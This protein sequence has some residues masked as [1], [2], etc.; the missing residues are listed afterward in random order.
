MKYILHTTRLKV[1]EFVPDD[2]PFIVDL[3]NTPGWIENIGDRNIHTHEDAT[4]YIH[5]GP[6]RSYVLHGFGLWLVEKRDDNAPLGMCGILKREYLNEPD[7]GFAFLP[8][9][10]GQGF[11]FEVASETINYA[12]DKLDIPVMSAITLAKNKSS[13][14]LLEKLGLSFKK[15]VHVA[16][17]KE[18]LLLFSN[19]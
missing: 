1:R 12:K 9:Y 7:I 15:I 5:N 17:T 10:H 6:M 13:I 16:D 3:V 18:D 8:Q 19:D 4:R 2:A 11:A 14:K